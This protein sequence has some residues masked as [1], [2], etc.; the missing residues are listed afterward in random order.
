MGLNC[1]AMCLECH[2]GELSLKAGFRRLR[3]QADSSHIGRQNDES[4]ANLFPPGCDNA[5]NLL[6]A[7]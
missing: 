6:S 4:G 2:P 5:V 7:P 1:Q 3:P